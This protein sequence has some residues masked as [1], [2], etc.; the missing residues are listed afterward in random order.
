M[1]TRAQQDSAVSGTSRR[2]Q[3][4]SSML[5]P[6]TRLLR[7]SE[8]AH[9]LGVSLSTVERL[10]A[11]GEFAGGVVR[12]RRTTRIRPE[13]VVRFIDERTGGATPSLKA[14]MAATPITPHLQAESRSTRAQLRE[15][16]GTR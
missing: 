6:L 8:V 9:H 11:D 7:L 14:D 15:I 10:V 3:V 5:I 16:R 12:F 2:T 1:G 4:T 13:A